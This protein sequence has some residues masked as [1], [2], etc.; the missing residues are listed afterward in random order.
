MNQRAFLFLEKWTSQSLPMGAARSAQQQ[1]RREQDGQKEQVG[2]GKEENIGSP[3]LG[4][5][6]D[7][8]LIGD[9]AGHGGDQGP[10]PAQVGPHE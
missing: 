4:V 1:G 7:E 8:E 2:P 9:Q 6:P 5:L 10:Q 3:L